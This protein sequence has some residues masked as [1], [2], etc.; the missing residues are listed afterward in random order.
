MVHSKR[1]EKDKPTMQD[2]G[3]FMGKALAEARKAGSLGEV[4]V[5]VVIVRDG[6]VLARGHNKK[7]SAGDPTAHA[8]IIALR[9]AARKLGNWRLEGCEV[10]VTLEPCVMCMGALVHARIGRLVFAATDKKAGACG[11]LYDLSQ[12]RRLNHC[13]EV[14]R[15]VM[16]EEAGELLKGFFKGLRSRSGNRSGNKIREKTVKKII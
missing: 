15:G 13:F 14:T 6:V 11:S 10:F 1:L 2:N 4:P 5:G 3:F 7:E 8:E 12:D 16:E 9:S